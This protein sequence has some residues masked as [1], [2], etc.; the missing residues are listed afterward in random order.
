MENVRIKDIGRAP[1]DVPYRTAIR[2]PGKSSF[3]G[4]GELNFNLHPRLSLEFFIYQR[5]YG[6]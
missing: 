1:R 2:P 5:S 3:S 4:L 6:G